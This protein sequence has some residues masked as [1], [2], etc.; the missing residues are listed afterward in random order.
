MKK[1]RLLRADEIECRISTI[2]KNGLSLLLYKTARTDAN[3]LDEAVG[4][5]NWQNDFKVVDGVLYGCI[6]IYDETRDC[7]IEKWDAGTESNTEA[8]KGRASDAFKRAGFKWGL[9]RELYTAPFI[10]IPS[11]SCTIEERG[12]KFYCNDRFRVV[13]IGYNEQNEI[14]HLDRLLLSNNFQ[15]VKHSSPYAVCL[16][17]VILCRHFYL[18]FK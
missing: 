15:G 14:N 18:I 8:E 10:W 6:S 5:E 17:L 12:A 9:G 16:N 3:L 13:D 11:T 1:F 4:S 2:K 7:W